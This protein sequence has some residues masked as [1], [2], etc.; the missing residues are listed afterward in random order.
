MIVVTDQIFPSGVVKPIRNREIKE[1]GFLV[2]TTI[3]FQSWPADLFAAFEQRK[4]SSSWSEK[5]SKFFWKLSHVDL[6]SAWRLINN[7][8]EVLEFFSAEQWS[9]WCSH[10]SWK[11]EV[12]HCLAFND[13]EKGQR[14]FFFDITKVE[15]GSLLPPLKR[16]LFGVTY[17]AVQS[18]QSVQFH[19]KLISQIWKEKESK[20]WWS[21]L[22]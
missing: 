19:Q 12:R 8:K 21:T 15:K 13:Q 3:K 1:E 11:V 10:A 14:N 4:A 18:V 9:K 20:I 16:R 6:Q 17:K 2:V 22:I 5:A 7:K